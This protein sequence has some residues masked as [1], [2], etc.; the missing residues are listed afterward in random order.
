ARRVLGF[1]LLAQLRFLGVDARLLLGL[2]GRFLFLEHA[3]LDV[4]ALLADFDADA[5]GRALPACEF[6]FADA[7]A[8]ERDVARLGAARRTVLAVRT[9][10]V[11]QKLQF[12]LVVDAVVRRSD[13]K[14]GFAELRQQTVD[15][16]TQHL[17]ELFY[18]DF[19]HLMPPRGSGLL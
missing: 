14:A 6:H 17:G 16:H 11:S 8:I 18:C 19:R 2:A 3:A 9:A 1:A 5:L 15:R 10:Q 4:R 12:L 7:A 13:V